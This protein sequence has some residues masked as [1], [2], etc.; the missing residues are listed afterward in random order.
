[1]DNYGKEAMVEITLHKVPDILKNTTLLQSGLKDKYHINVMM[2]KRSG[3]VLEIN[4]DTIFL[5]KDTIIVFGLYQSIK[6]VFLKL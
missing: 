5:E 2:L 6:D 1:M 3:V 4:K